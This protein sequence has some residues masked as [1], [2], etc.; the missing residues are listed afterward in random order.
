MDIKSTDLHKIAQNIQA[1]PENLNQL[2]ELRKLLNLEETT[3]KQ[4]IKIMSVVS[5][6]LFHY[7]EADVFYPDIE[8]DS[9]S[10]YINTEFKETISAAFELLASCEERQKIDASLAILRL[11]RIY[12]NDAEIEKILYFQQL[13]RSLVS[14]SRETIWKLSRR[15]ID[16]A[17]Y[18]LRVLYQSISQLIPSSSKHIWESLIGMPHYQEISETSYYL[19]SL[20][21]HISKKRKRQ[22]NF[23]PS[24][25]GSKVAIDETTHEYQY[26]SALNKSWKTFLSYEL[27][28]SLYKPILKSIPKFVL[29]KISDPLCLSDFLM[30]TYEMGGKMSVL[31]LS[32]L[33]ILISKYGLECK[34]YYSKLYALLKYQLEQSSYLKPGF[35]KLVELSLS[36]NL[37]PAAL[38]A[39]FVKLFLRHA[40]KGSYQLSVWAVGFTMNSIRTHPSLQKLLERPSNI[41]TYSMQETDPLNSDALNSSLWE[42]LILKKHYS[43]NIRDLLK[44]ITKDPLMMPKLNLSELICNLPEHTPPPIYAQDYLTNLMHHT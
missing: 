18:I 28:I 12:H 27:P 34:Q 3:F 33:F 16:L 25:N 5:D 41:E 30:K 6:V 22:E 35:L 2:T 8:K 23:D 1:N 19:R 11:V 15:Y 7:V 40:I 44:D 36:S 4:K 38:V 39:S 10:T 21:L 9:V 14:C 29:P 37:L 31:G 32:G 26:K 43:I 17:I 13:V 20:N 42:I 24:V